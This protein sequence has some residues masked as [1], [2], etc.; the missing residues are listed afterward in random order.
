MASL[1]WL[2]SKKTT[3]WINKG[4]ELFVPPVLSDRKVVACLFN[5]L[6]G[7][8]FRYYDVTKSP[9]NFPRCNRVS[10]T[11][12]K[13]ESAVKDLIVGAKVLD[14]GCGRGAF[15]KKLS[16]CGFETVGVDPNQESIKGE[17][18]KILKGFVEDF[19]FQSKPF[20]TVCSFK[21]LE[22]IPNAKSTLAYWK[23]LSKYRIILILPCQRY[24]KYVYD[25]H[26]NFY[27][28]EYQLRMQLGLG[29][30][31]VVKKIDGDWLVYEDTSKVEVS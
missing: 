1:E 8:G 22:H 2:L 11:T 19:D 23:K 28:D 25:G 21:A 13:Q 15:I 31:A 20:D 14:I 4:L 10:D 17:N 16:A 3:R 24:R 27:P 9:V 7:R 29:D 18:W 30:S 12:V 6:Q 26:I 5:F